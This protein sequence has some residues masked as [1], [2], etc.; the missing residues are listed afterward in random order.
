MTPAPR[1]SRTARDEPLNSYD[2]FTRL[3]D[4]D[5]F[6]YLNEHWS[7]DELRILHQGNTLTKVIEANTSITNLQSDVFLFKASIS[8]SV[9]AISNGKGNRVSADYGNRSQAPARAGLSG[10]TV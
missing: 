6:F 7:P 8:G 9:L 5:R 1:K 4:G 3:R 10:A 2:Q